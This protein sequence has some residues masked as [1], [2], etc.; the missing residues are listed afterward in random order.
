[1]VPARQ[2]HGHF[3][4]ARLRRRVLRRRTPRHRQVYVRCSPSR[5]TSQSL[6]WEST[7]ALGRRARRNWHHGVCQQGQTTAIGR[8]GSRTG[9]ARCTTRT[10]TSTPARGTPA[11]STARYL[12]LKETAT[13]VTGVGLQSAVQYVRRQVRQLV[14]RGVLGV[15]G[16]RR[17]RRG[18]RVQPRGGAKCT[19]TT[20]TLASC[21][22]AWNTIR[23]V[24]PTRRDLE[25]FAAGRVGRCASAGH[26]PQPSSC[27]PLED[28]TVRPA[29]AS[30]RCLPPLA[31]AP[32]MQDV[33]P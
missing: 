22:R 17:L 1:M 9:R 7:M 30:T 27:A 26:R 8:M 2:G 19:A 6:R 4:M 29:L 3:R 24:P 21:G 31:G 5:R 16:Q 32:R 23:W 14:H 33:D 11:R 25:P 18:R 15:G 28:E 10:A 20:P 13:K 12:L